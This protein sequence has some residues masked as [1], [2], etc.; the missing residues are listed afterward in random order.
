MAVSQKV[1]GS[2]LAIGAVSAIAVG[3]TSFAS[4][5]SGS[6]SNSLVDRIA[7]KFNLNKDEVKA[8]FNEEH[9][10][11]AAERLADV[12]Q[13]LQKD[14]DAG[15]LTAD[16]KTLIETKLKEIQTAREAQRAEL[17]AWAEDNNIDAKYIMMG[18]RHG[19]A[20]NRLQDAV[21]DGDITAEQKTLI[22]AKQKEFQTARETQRTALEQWAKDNGIDTD[23]LHMGGK[24]EHRGGGPRE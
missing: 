21:D 5:E 16:Q 11:R 8:V 7:N 10:A 9:A 20:S 13:D 24:G 2:M 18:G 23:Y 1:L 14:V 17:D 4:A 12:S 22:E 15:D 6:N 3:V 19:D